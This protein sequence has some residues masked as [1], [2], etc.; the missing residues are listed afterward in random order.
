MPAEDPRDQYAGPN[1]RFEVPF[2]LEHAPVSLNGDGREA[3]LLTL[4]L[5]FTI[6]ANKR[7]VSMQKDGGD[8][9]LKDTSK[10]KD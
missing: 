9:T 4:P 2:D 10:S 7:G 1:L 6:R 5:G 3:F 8:V